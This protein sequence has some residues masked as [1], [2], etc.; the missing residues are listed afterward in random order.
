[1]LYWEARVNYAKNSMEPEVLHN[2]HYSRVVH[3]DLGMVHYI[4]D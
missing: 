2:L 4:F 1:M 3:P